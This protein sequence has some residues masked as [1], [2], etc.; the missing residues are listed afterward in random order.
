MIGQLYTQFYNER[1]RVNGLAKTIAFNSKK[2]LKKWWAV[3]DLN[4]N[5][6]E[7]IYTR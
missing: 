1:T 5:E 2:K 6:K 4:Q 3:S 7:E